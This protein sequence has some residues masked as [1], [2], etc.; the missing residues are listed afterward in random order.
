M[1]L[2]QLTCRVTWDKEG[3]LLVTETRHSGPPHFRMIAHS[4]VPP[5]SPPRGA[6]SGNL[7]ATAT[8]E[9]FYNLLK[10][11][12]RTKSCRCGS[13]YGTKPLQRLTHRPLSVGCRV[14]A[15]LARLW[16]TGIMAAN[17]VAGLALRLRNSPSAGPFV[18]LS[19]RRYHLRMLQ[20]YIG[21][22]CNCK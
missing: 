16:V 12:S 11:C 14:L 15:T 2:G 13:L 20:Q 1:N 9:H 17:S 6:S 5:P 21:L 22:K 4:Q 7:S 3:R 10:E 19:E 8:F 18:R